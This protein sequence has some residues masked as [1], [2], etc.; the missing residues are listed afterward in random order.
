M[1]IKEK[2]K[3]LNF[4]EANIYVGSTTIN[5]NFTR[6]ALVSKTNIKTKEVTFVVQRNNAVKEFT[7]L[8][9]ACGF[10]DEISSR[11]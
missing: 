11:K 4:V 1:S 6:I 8:D 9:E 5:Y 2:I 3:D 7:D 10:F